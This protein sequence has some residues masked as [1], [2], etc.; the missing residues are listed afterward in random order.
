MTTLTLTVVDI[1]D[2]VPGI[3]TLTLADADGEVLPSFTPG[4]HLVIECAGG[5]NAYSLTG[6]TAAPHLYVVSVLECPQGRGGSRWIHR[7][8]GVGDTVVAHPP[9][10]A[11]APVL[12]ARRHLLIAAGIGITP[13]ISHLRTAKRWGRDVLLLYVFREGRGAYVD[14]ISS[15]TDNASFFT[16]RAAF[17]AELAPALV[18]QPFGTH[19][20]ICGPSQFIDVVVA[21]AAELGWPPSR[22][23]VEHFGGELAPGDPF[24]VELSSSGEVFTVESGASLLEC[25]TTHGHSIPNLCRQ[26][27]CGECRVTVRSGTV[28]HRDLFL[29]D[30]ERR[31]SMMACVSRGRG[32]VE[33]EL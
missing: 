20:Y 9:R 21:M 30:D 23:H 18:G 4:S 26:G 31:H 1:D 24:E 2:T 7:Q 33:L 22:I 14:E 27:V 17:L 32:R 29:T 12:R 8:L 3:R 15:L 11:F 13:M 6:E 28:L 10:S 5:A 19:A 25:L 16:D